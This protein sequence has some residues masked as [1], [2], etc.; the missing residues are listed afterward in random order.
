MLRI[1]ITILLIIQFTSVL[2]AATA[3]TDIN[4]LIK[5]YH[6]KQSLVAVKDI[7][8]WSKPT[9]V[10]IRVDSKERLKWFNQVVAEDVEL[11]AV[12]NESEVLRNIDNAQVVM[13]F[14]SEEIIR[15]GRQLKWIQIYGSGA[16]RCIKHL[17]VKPNNMILSNGQR[18]AGTEIAEH[19]IAL[20]FSLNRGLDQ[21]SIA[22]QKSQWQRDI[23]PG[24]NVIWELSGRT[25]LVVGL[26]GIGSEVARRGHALGMNVIAT[27]NSSRE[28]PEYVSYV[29]LPDELLTLTAKADIVINALPLTTSTKGLFDRTFFKT[30][31]S[32]AYFISIGRGKSTVTDDLLAALKA[33]E[34]AGAGLDVV[35]PEPLPAEHPLWKQPRVIITPHIAWRS[36]RYQQRRWLMLR[37]N[38]R[39][40]VNGEALLSEV[41]L[42]KGY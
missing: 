11:V 30:M 16:E 10:L 38:L 28:G 6:L 15:K 20:M 12:S 37:E 8:G 25:M 23:L 21:Y 1:I 2:T 26:G 34:L 29:G 36:E 22:Q 27:R 42:N 40:Y 14:C 33:G 18:L 24:A 4:L 17:S 32:N 41:D 5:S 35:D 7:D 3:E 19:A 39:R 9:K 13:G 31:K